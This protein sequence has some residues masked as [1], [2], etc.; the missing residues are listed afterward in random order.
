MSLD[1]LVSR[2]EVLRSRSTAADRLSERDL[3]RQALIEEFG[4][5]PT[6]EPEKGSGVV[7]CGQTGVVWVT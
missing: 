3:A 1:D 2:V 5:E 4:V 6:A 7:S